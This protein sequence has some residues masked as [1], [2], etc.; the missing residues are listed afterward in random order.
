LPVDQ[1]KRSLLLFLV[2][3]SGAGYFLWQWDSSDVL[4]ELLELAVDYSRQYQVT[5]PDHYTLPV[6]YGDI[7]P[8]LLTAGTIDY[9]QFVEV[10]NRR[11]HSLT[12]AQQNILQHGSDEPIVINRENAYFLLNFF[13]AFGLTNQNAILDDGPLAQYAD[14]DI[15]NFA[16][17]GGWTIGEKPATELYSSTPIVVL[18]IEQQ[19]RLETV[20][21]AVYRPCC[22][23]HTAFADC[24]HGMAMLGVLEGMASQ[25][26]SLDEMFEA[27]KYLNA[28]WF[29][30]HT[31]EL[32]LFFQAMYGQDFASIDSRQAVGTTYFSASGFRSLHQFLTESNILQQNNRSE[33]NCG[34]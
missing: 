33:G 6:T 4:N 2:L 34:I 15:G 31:M 28:F 11:G 13:W 3:V 22:N 21:E 20:A 23:N 14:G 5:L 26:A 10:Y 1:V 18:N 16:S 17:T 7:G 8:Q 9:E 24:N 29:P 27:A 32:A 30:Q 19:V 12:D 25:D